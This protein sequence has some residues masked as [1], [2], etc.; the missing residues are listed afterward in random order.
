MPNT[1]FGVDRQQVSGQL[2]HVPR[3]DRYQVKWGPLATELQRLAGTAPSDGMTYVGR[4]YSMTSCAVGQC[5]GEEEKNVLLQRAQVQNCSV[6]AEARSPLSSGELFISLQPLS[7]LRPV[8]FCSIARGGSSRGSSGSN[9]PSP[10]LTDRRPP[11]EATCSVRSRAL[12][13]RQARRRSS[14]RPRSREIR[15][16]SP[17]GERTTDRPSDRYSSLTRSGTRSPRRRRRRR[18]SRHW[19]RG[20]GAALEG[21]SHGAAT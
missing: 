17:L 8:P 7:V 3:R 15:F 1:V 13:L 10:A 6:T 9:R 12:P 16:P 21:N 5:G 11:P 20:G 2:A 14:V 18:L 4:A 19:G